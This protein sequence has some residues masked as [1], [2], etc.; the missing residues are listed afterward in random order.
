[1]VIVELDYSN[2]FM[3]TGYGVKQQSSTTSLAHLG[4]TPKQKFLFW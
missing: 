1:M 4:K 2:S 3:A